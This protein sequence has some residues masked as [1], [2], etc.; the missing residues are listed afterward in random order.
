MRAYDVI[1]II[2]T[3]Y[4]LLIRSLL[5]FTILDATKINHMHVH[6]LL[7]IINA[8]TY[9]MSEKPVKYS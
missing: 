3:L 1:S 9:T 4:P 8:M 7:Q 2:L 6:V 5:D